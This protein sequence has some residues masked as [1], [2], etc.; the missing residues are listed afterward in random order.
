MKRAESYEVKP[1]EMTFKMLRGMS[2][3]GKFRKKKNVRRSR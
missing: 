1:K 2:S 3:K